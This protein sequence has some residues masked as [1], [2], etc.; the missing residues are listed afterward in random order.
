MKNASYFI[1]TELAQE[2]NIFEESNNDVLDNNGQFWSSFNIK[3]SKGKNLF[4]VEWLGNLAVYAKNKNESKVSST[5]NLRYHYK[6]SPSL[7]FSSY[8]NLFNKRWEREKSGYSNYS[9]VGII[10]YNIGSLTSTVG[11]CYGKM[12]YPSFNKFNFTQNGI[13][14]EF[15]RRFKSR[16]SLNLKMSYID[17][18]Y[19]YREVFHEESE[20]ESDIP[21]QRDRILSVQIGGEYK[22][23][24]I[25]GGNCNI[26]Y[27]KS[28]SCY[29]SFRGVSLRFYAT[30]QIFNTIIQAIADIQVKKYTDE[31]T[32]SLIYFN[33][34]PEQNLQ[35]QLFIGWEKPVI[36]A[37]SVTGKI[38][39][40]RNETR[41]SGI[42]YDKWFFSAGIQ[43][44]FE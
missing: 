10:G 44:R 11:L 17:V 35:N 38:A 14:L 36:G 41:Y 28:N 18:N 22:K 21:L 27:T 19:P 1:K 30:R 29:S 9:G 26:F 37:L 6:F 16:S 5:I 8:I 34:D 32:D 25:A 13:I 7:T 23:R 24:M 39:F 20:N 4:S 40:M 12:S 15:L 3:K 42:Y 43:Y 33:P 2:S 31:P